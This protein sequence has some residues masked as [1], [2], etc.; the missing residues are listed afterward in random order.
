MSLKGLFDKVAITKIVDNKTSA[1]IGNVVESADYHEADIIDEKRYLPP[2]DFSEPKN[3]AKY[4]SAKQYYI[5]SYKYIYSSYPYDGSLAE[6]LQWKNSGSY[7]D[8]YVFEHKY[9]RTTGY[10]NFSF[11]GWGTPAASPATTSGYG[12]PDDSDSYEYISIKGGPGLG[13]GIQS[14]SANVWDPDNNRE[15][16]LEVDPTEGVT[17]EFWLKKDAFNAAN[18]EK[19][20]VL[21]VWNNELSSSDSYGR[22]RIELTGAAPAQSWMVTLMSG[23]TGF[24]TTAIG[25]ST[26]AEVADGDWHHYAFSFLSAS[27]GVATRYYVDGALRTQSTL[28]STGVNKITGSMLAY[29]GA[30]RTAASGTSTAAGYGKL[31]GS[32]DEFRYWKTRRSSEKIGR[33]WFTQVG[34][35]T[36][37]DIANTN[38]GV[39]YKFNEGI[40]G[41]AATDATILDF[42][43]RV[44]NGTWTGYTVGSRNTGSAMVSASAT[45]AEFQDP[46]IY[47]THPDVQSTLEVLKLS[48][49]AHDDVN[50][51][52]LFSFF[53]SWM[54]DQDPQNG[55]ELKKLTQ[56][57]SSYFDTLYLQIESFGSI[58]DVAYL[59]GSATKANTVAESLLASKGLLAPELFLD[60]DILEKLG[61]R[62]E[63]REYRESLTNIKNK[64]YQNIYNNLVSI[65]KAKGTRASFRNMLRCFGVDEEI[66]RLNVYGSNVQFK[67]RNNRE[68]DSTK[69]RFIDFSKNTA[70]DATVFLSGSGEVNS[71]PYLAGGL[72]LTSGYAST[73]ETYVFF[74]KKPG[75]FE[76]A[77]GEY[78]Y[79]YIT[80]SLFGQ[81]TVTE[82]DP[83]TLSWDNPDSTNFQVYAVRDELESTDAHFLLTCSAGGVMPELSSS[84]YDDVYSN[85][86][87]IFGVSIKPTEAPL[88]DFIDGTSTAD[89]TVYFRGAQVDAGE[90]INSF[91][92]TGSI[93]AAQAGYGFLTGSKRLYVG[94]HRTNFTGTL[95]N[96][97]D[98]RV[99]FCRYWLQ[100]IE[101]DLLEDH[102]KDVHNY[103]TKFPSRSP[104]LF[105]DS[106]INN[107]EFLELDTLALNWDFETVTGSDAS[108][109]FNVA[110]F[111]SGS[112]AA[113]SARYGNLGNLLAA[114]HPGYGYGFAASTTASVDTDYVLA[115][116]LQ[117]FERLNSNDMISVLTV[118]DDVEFTR[119][120][121]PV[122][123]VYALEKSMYQTISENMIRM[124]AVVNDFNN[125]IG[126]PANRY[127]DSY[128]ALRI[129]RERFFEKVEN[130]PD[131]D[132]YIEFYK[133]F[134]SSLSKILE[135]LI[136]AGAEFSEEIRTVVESH[137]LERSK[138]K[139]QFPTLDLKTADIQGTVLSPLPL[140]PGWEFTHHPVNDQENTNANYWKN[141]ASRLSGKL[142]SA[143]V[144]VNSDKQIYFDNTTKES[145][146]RKE[147]NVYRFIGKRS[148]PI[149]AGATT[150]ENKKSNFV[151]AATAPYGPMVPGT[152]IPKNVM[153]SFRADV[154]LLPNVVDDLHP[155]KKTRLGFGI[156]PTINID[157]GQKRQD[158]NILAPFSLYSS[159]VVS[160]Y[161]SEISNF[162]T[163][164]V[165]LTNL[166]EDIVYT[167]ESRPL[168][169]PFTEKFVGGRQYRHTDLNSGSTL[170]TRE[171]RAEGFRILLAL[172]SGIPS[173][174]PSGALG[175]VPPNYPFPTSLM[176]EVTGGFLPRLP[177]AQRLRDEGA[178]RPVN[179]KNILMTTASAGVRLSG[180]ILHGRLGNYTKNYQVI[181]TGGRTNNDPFFQDQTFNFAA[182]PLASNQTVR[183]R[184]PLS[185]ADG[186]P[187]TPNVGFT[188]HAIPERTGSDSNASIFVNKFS[189][190]GGYSSISPG[191][192]DPAHEEKS[193]YNVLSYR[194]LG[195]LNFGTIQSASFDASIALT[196]HVE[197]ESIGT[198][199]DRGLRQR[200]VPH[201]QPYGY[202]GQ[203]TA[204]PAYY[205]VNRNAR[206]RYATQRA[207]DGSYEGT[208]E[209]IYDNYFVHHPIPRTTHQYSWISASWDEDN[210]TTSTA[211]WG[212]SEL[213]GGF[214]VP[215]L[216]LISRSVDYADEPFVYFVVG[217]IDPVSAATNTLGF[218]LSE[219]TS[220]YLNADYWNQPT[221]DK[222][223]DMFNTLML[224]RNGPYQAPSW[225]QLRYSNHPVLT[226]HKK[227]S[228][229]S[230]RIKTRSDIEIGARRGNAIKQFVEPQV[231]G[232]EFPLIHSM[233]MGAGRDMHI[234]LKSSYGNKLINYA[235]YELNNL[236]NV[237]RDYKSSDLYFNRINSMIMR[238]T[239]NDATVRSLFRDVR[240]TYAQTVYPAT[241]NA[242][243]SRTR[244]RRH[245]SINNIW[246]NIRSSRSRGP[247]ENSQGFTIKTEGYGMNNSPSIWPLDGHLN[248]ST[249]VSYAVDDGA[250]E[251]QN[252]YSRFPVLS[253]NP[254]KFSNPQVKAAA[255]Y[256]ARI[257][258]GTISS[259]ANGIQDAIV[260]DRYNLVP[261]TTSGSENPA[262]SG[263]YPYQ[264]YEEYAK[265]LRLIGKDYSIVP[266]FLISEHLS[267]FLNV[268][269]DFTTLSDIDDLLSLT[270]S[271]YANSSHEGFYREYG[272]SDFMKMFEVV[273]GAYDGAK[274]AD[275][276]EMSQDKI[277]L[278]CNALLQF[279]PYKGFYPAERTEA[280]A[281]LLS[282]SY[283]PSTFLSGTGQ[284]KN[285][286][287]RA[288]LEPLYSQGVMYNTIKSGIAVSNFI[289]SN[290]ASSPA[291]ITPNNWPAGS[292]ISGS[293]VKN[294]S[295]S[296]LPEGNLFFEYMLPPFRSVDGAFSSSYFNENGYFFQKVPF[297]ALYKPR[298]FL[299]KD[300][301][302]HTG[303]IYDTGVGSSSLELVDSTSTAN[304]VTWDGEGDS[305]YEL[306]IDNFLCETVNFFQNGLTSI[307]SDREE[308]FGTVQS[309]SVYTMTMKL[310]RPTTSSVG[311][312]WAPSGTLIPDYNKF[313][314]YRRISAFG[315]PLASRDWDASANFFGSAS[316][317]SSFSHLTPPYFAGSGSATFTFTATY[318]G[319]P[320]LDEIFAGTTITY[321]RM[322][323]VELKNG[324]GSGNNNVDAWKVQMNDSFNLTSSISTVPASSRTQRKQWLIQ[325][326]FETPIININ[327][328]R[329]TCSSGSV[330]GS[331]ATG[332]ITF[333]R[334]PSS[335]AMSGT[336]VSWPDGLG[337]TYTFVFTDSTNVQANG[338]QWKSS[339]YNWEVFIVNADIEDTRDNLYHAITQSK[340]VDSALNVATTDGTS[341]INLQMRFTGSAY[342]QTIADTAGSYVTPAGFAGGLDG[343]DASP[344]GDIYGIIDIAT[345]P[346]TS[347]P[348]NI[349]GLD[350]T[351]NDEL[352]TQGL[353]HDY[354]SIPSGSDEGVFA[355]IESPSPKEGNSLAEVVGMPFGQQFRIGA[356]KHGGVLEEALV[357]VPFFVGEDDRRKFYKI[358]D[359]SSLKERDTLTAQLEK[360][361]FPPRFD[362]VRNPT[363]DP[364]AMYVFEFSRNVSQ[365]DIADMWQ[366]L[367]PSIGETFS[368]QVVEIEHKL[369]RD[370]LLNQE[371]RPLRS[372]LR[373]LV[374]KVKRRAAM[375][376]S[377]FS[378][379][380]LVE[381]TSTIPSGIDN[382][383]YSYNWPYDYFS[384]IE[385]VKIDEAIEYASEYPAD[386]TVAIVGDVNITAPNGIALIDRNDD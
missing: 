258:H 81:H 53:P 220:S 159:S 339:N 188:E 230:A 232:S 327:G 41:V 74:P 64:I 312:D 324:G 199:V 186:T 45:L 257:W 101:I 212:Y 20:V 288:F 306:A 139:H 238:D 13:G 173:G 122:N 221:F 38:L 39:Y 129:L 225:K 305:L 331:H 362:F 229:I 296:P 82:A 373:W 193:V 135:Q 153:L 322:E 315:P 68:L 298:N 40:T 216:P 274:L 94:A 289:V 200:L 376:Y 169:G 44:T 194:N 77:Y 267:E 295:P 262:G 70:F 103:G 172:E 195:V 42:S 286:L 148:I 185:N 254:F 107:S 152:N 110:D 259:S 117:D 143:D 51:S 158:G 246:D 365:Q 321:D 24:Q 242:Y 272:N 285:G 277:G 383:A 349:G 340:W 15:S 249:T 4:G 99:G 346:T 219:A 161:N 21:D 18:T 33:Y 9:P 102:G 294:V 303:R 375:D 323:T 380:R 344:C 290:T 243:L 203:Y 144:N 59:S 261:G 91:V 29:I 301:I 309:G 201:N 78:K 378:K 93:N 206:P 291:T 266:E 79:S 337:N 273:N 342:N 192:L 160:G 154:E 351:P 111:S 56:I 62:S 270:G 121:R 89:H 234:Q 276:S 334:A 353:W 245:Y 145:R 156:D 175:I 316:Y 191:Y 165:M 218:D 210:S 6:K 368:Q 348:Q 128:K 278:R 252:S 73:V 197:D 198:G 350:L 308:N 211:R 280:L 363:M 244:G 215:S 46:I 92:V 224:N 241:Y 240:A 67:I 264:T 284:V 330:S 190:P 69:K 253:I 304:Y 43:G 137:I 317:E 370:R 106:Q 233:H 86:N 14:Q 302:R 328:D 134:D 108:G 123:F 300:Y 168:Q 247:L 364:I 377:K 149:R 371:D 131:L 227:N 164:S 76:P 151:F 34:G 187:A 124:F 311:Y 100:D 146:A 19:E 50:P 354:G 30:L 357:A 265:Y 88:V 335:A 155:G 176:A 236:L 90:V 358:D 22:F 157:P 329:R 239:N 23:T 204:Y 49:S 369:V 170:D 263:K 297:E 269:E 213:S 95:L 382:A 58:H 205:K 256:N 367:P 255:T 271:G 71:V 356:V 119:E 268:N 7:I 318:D 235:N 226:S 275:G 214:F 140:S 196:M 127:R 325:S 251:L 72:P 287:Y 8:L 167:N 98:V 183:G 17:V 25:D 116:E 138:Y 126:D 26:R 60:A 16:N 281:G 61:D 320:T 120:S 35:G 223:E 341:A 181:Q 359:L 105:E 379:S 177:T 2:I 109:E 260:G 63:Q 355:I 113:Q 47:S 52:E 10:I 132:K 142:A 386:T 336:N 345:P 207:P 384:L 80:A 292:G 381:D 352:Y 54:Q 85:T 178:K 299:D 27:S 372:D 133:W 97:S 202:D 84:F 313:D 162:Y 231:Y 283:G 28:G 171:T 66:Y 366:N 150:Q 147:R 136:P 130:T 1:Q 174:I 314:M 32:L 237:Q 208:V 182:N 166:H 248:Y 36:N 141:R 347:L 96:R 293:A 114:Q 374:F 279:L 222:N 361:V 104:Y 307:V 250:G 180:T 343:Q 319:Q 31:S 125:I 310:Y 163:A 57:I 360:Y 338:G 37:T 118:Q 65:Y 12:I 3:F 189:A 75:A 11:G 282:Q 209:Q 228:V 55:D 184:F 87:W 5:D 217:L 48:G 112:A 326:K 83:T 332:S 179:I 385:L 333:V 115:A